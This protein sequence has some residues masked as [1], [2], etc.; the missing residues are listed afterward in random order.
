MSL[1]ARF[2][3]MPRAARW[4]IAFVA[5]LGAY[6][7]VIEPALDSTLRMNSSSEQIE[8]HLRGA[9]TS[10]QGF[11]S[12]L[13]QVDSGTQRFGTVNLPVE[14]TAGSEA[15][16]RRIAEILK[17]H[18]VRDS[19]ASDREVPVASGPLT[20][21]YAPDNMR[22]DRLVKDLQFESTPDTVA[23]VIADCERAPEIVAVSRVQITK[24]QSGRGV[25]AGT[26]RANITVEAWKLSRKG[27]A[28]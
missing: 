6:F 24:L 5:G 12:A 13:G 28:R 4:L 25:P 2:N 15:F 11:V 22:L 9:S 20:Q 21:V 19:T 17:A 10:D 3:S 7:L 14:S 8:S 1:G 18:G 16:N 26:V 27:R 23:R